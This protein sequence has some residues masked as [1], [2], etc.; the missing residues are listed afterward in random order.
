MI[1]RSVSDQ[2]SYFLY[3]AHTAPHWPLHARD[4]DIARY[5]DVYTSG[6]DATR[7]ARHEEMNSLDLFQTC[8]D[9]S[10]RD[11]AVLDWR[12]TDLKGWEASKMST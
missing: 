9:I 2:Q 7:T 5:K 4:E 6:W 1:E 11:E 8:W 10:P 12:D 3:L